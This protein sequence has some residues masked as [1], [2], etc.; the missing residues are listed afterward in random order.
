MI[1]PASAFACAFK[2]ALTKQ[3]ASST[4]IRDGSLMTSRSPRSPLPVAQ[5]MQPKSQAQ[6]VFAS[7]GGAQP[8]KGQ[9]TRV[10][11]SAACGAIQCRQEAKGKNNS[12]AIL[13]TR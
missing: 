8:A 2:P 12:S 9:A 6:R 10:L 4:V 3:P 7:R 11:N 5:L 1:L 13:L